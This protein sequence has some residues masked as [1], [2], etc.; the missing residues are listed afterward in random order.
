M[1]KALLASLMIAFLAASCS[2]GL[3]T[4]AEESTLSQTTSPST[5]V[6]RPF[7]QHTAYTEV[8]ILPNHRSQEQLDQDVRDFYDYWKATYVMDA[9][10]DDMGNPLYR[11]AWWDG[12]TT[13]KDCFGGARVRHDYCGSDGRI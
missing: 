11:I 5:T 7:P 8:S 6:N 3:S 9:G 12:R 13:S 4:P 10:Q 1:K 2:G